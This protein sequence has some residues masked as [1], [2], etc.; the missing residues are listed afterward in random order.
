MRFLVKQPLALRVCSIE[1]LPLR[2]GFRSSVGLLVVK[3]DPFNSEHYSLHHF[4]DRAPRPIVFTRLD[5]VQGL[6]VTFTLATDLRLVDK[7]DAQVTTLYRV[8]CIVSS[9]QA[10]SGFNGGIRGS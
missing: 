3:D 1:S 7:E 2:L 10:D 8:T 6:K 5:L 4:L 9:C